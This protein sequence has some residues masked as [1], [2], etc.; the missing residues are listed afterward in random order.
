MDLS[1][2][3]QQRQIL[4]VST[5]TKNIKR[6]LEES[7]PF[8]WISGEISNLRIPSSGH[9]YFTLKDDKSQVAA[10]IFKGQLRQ[11]AFALEDGLTI[12]GLCRV[13]V[14]EPRGTYQ[15]IFEYIE[16]KGAGALQLAF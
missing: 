1:S 9:A 15:V 5:L 10:V 3:Q 4:T 8:I 12:V 16:P 11:M 6:I 14:Y 2:S 7:F 13:T